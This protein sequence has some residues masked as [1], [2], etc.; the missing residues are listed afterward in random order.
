MGLTSCEKEIDVDLKSASPRIVIE[1]TVKQNQYATVCVSSTI[2]FGNNE[3]YPNLSG[4]VVTVSDDKG[5][6]EQLKQDKNGW[7]TAEKIKGEV[8]R[9]YN[10]TVV[11]DGQEYKATSQMPPQVPLD[12]VTMSKKI[13]VMDY[14]FPVIN[15]QDPVGETNQYYRFLL[16]INGKQLPDIEE[17]VLSADLVDG[18]YFRQDW[19]VYRNGS[20]EDPYE[21]GDE[22]TIE[23]QCIDK[24][25]YKFF[26]SMRPIG[27]SPTNAISN[28]SNG[29]LG[30]FSACTSEKKT[31]I[32]DWED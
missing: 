16:F 21:K 22:L 24:G 5:N 28:I 12:S 23:F 26:N 11:Y 1:G 25:T 31:I 2:D 3:G 13:P 4:A 19:I 15:F 6:S 7:Y 8:G 29:A 30:Y 20:D 27:Q 18:E 17:F 32:A 9:I 14:T 10:M